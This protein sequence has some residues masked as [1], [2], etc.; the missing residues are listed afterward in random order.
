MNNVKKKIQ[1]IQGEKKTE[2]KLKGMKKKNEDKMKGKNGKM[3][4]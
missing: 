2:R 4:E 1:E 3:K